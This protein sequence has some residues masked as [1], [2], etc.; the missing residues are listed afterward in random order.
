[1]IFPTATTLFQG[2]MADKIL[3]G[4]AYELGS[5]FSC[6]KKEQKIKKK[7]DPSNNAFFIATIKIR[8]KSAVI[9]FIYIYSIVSKHGAS[10]N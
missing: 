9:T 7:F 1:M 3:G 2:M 10:S 4:G 5:I 8:S 6:R